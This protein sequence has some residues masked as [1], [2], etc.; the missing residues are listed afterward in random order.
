YEGQSADA[1]DPFPIV[2]PPVGAQ[3]RRR[4]RRH[5]AFRKGDHYRQPLAPAKLPCRLETNTVSAVK[6]C[7]PARLL[8]RTIGASEVGNAGRAGA[9]RQTDLRSRLQDREI[10]AIAGDIPVEFVVILEMADLA[11]RLVGNLVD[12]HAMPQQHVRI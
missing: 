4:G 6:S 7:G 9:E 1:D 8:S 3:L 10:P 2:P 5:D 11:R 12:M